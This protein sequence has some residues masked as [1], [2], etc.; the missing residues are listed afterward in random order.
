MRHSYSWTLL[1]LQRQ[2]RRAKV[3]ARRKGKYIHT[4]W[5]RK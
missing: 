4:V 5:G 3:I 1:Y 2:E